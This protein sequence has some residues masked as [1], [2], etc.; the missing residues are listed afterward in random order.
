MVLNSEDKEE[1][2]EGKGEKERVFQLRNQM[3]GSAQGTAGARHGKQ[4]DARVSTG[5][6][7]MRRIDVLQA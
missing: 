6:S 3:L 1:G 7:Q 5:D 4:R 2:R